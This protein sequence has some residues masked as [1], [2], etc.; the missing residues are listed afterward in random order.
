MWN[1]LW[2]KEIEV[3][4]AVLGRVPYE[5]VE[6]ARRP[7][8]PSSHSPLPSIEATTTSSCTETLRNPGVAQ[9]TIAKDTKSHQGSKRSRRI[10]RR[11][12]A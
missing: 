12:Y 1:S 2:G 9:W 10:S 4:A 5:G 6:P 8:S 7:S 11:H 3:S